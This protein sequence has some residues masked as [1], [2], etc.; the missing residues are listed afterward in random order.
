MDGVDRW[1]AGPVSQ[2]SVFVVRDPWLAPERCCGN[3]FVLVFW[4]PFGQVAARWI[5]FRHRD[6][7]NVPQLRERARFVAA[8]AEV[9]LQ[10]GARARATRGLTT[11]LVIPR[12]RMPWSETADNRAATPRGSSPWCPAEL[13]RRES[14]RD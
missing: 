5:W 9:L 3:L 14:P 10:E 11:P 4:L 1:L 2:P 6:S 7:A 12:R 13:P 8:Q